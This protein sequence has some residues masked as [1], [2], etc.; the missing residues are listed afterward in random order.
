[1]D[2][3]DETMQGNTVRFTQEKKIKINTNSEDI[4]D[5]GLDAPILLTK[6]DE[7]E[8]NMNNAGWR[9]RSKRKAGG[10]T[11]DMPKIRRNPFIEIIP[12]N[13]GQVSFSF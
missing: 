10:A 12:I 4:E 9:K 13:T 1:M 6:D 3:V 5:A 2:V 7:I 8:S 11:L